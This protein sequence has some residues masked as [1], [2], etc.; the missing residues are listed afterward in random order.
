[1]TALARLTFSFVILCVVLE[2]VPLT[3][4][5]RGLALS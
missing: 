5:A 4:V 1:M 2:V 3:S